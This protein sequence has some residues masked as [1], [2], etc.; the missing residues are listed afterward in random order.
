MGSIAA[1][2]E[3]DLV[4]IE[5]HTRGSAE[6]IARTWR[7]GHVSEAIRFFLLGVLTLISMSVGLQG[8]TVKQRPSLSAPNT[9]GIP[10]SAPVL[11]GVPADGVLTL[12]IPPGAAADQ[13]LGGR[14]YTM[15]DV[16]QLTAGD[17]IVLRNDDSVPHMILYAFLMPGQTHE[18]TLL[19]PGSEVYSSGCGVH[20]AS[21]LNF[22]TIFVSEPG[23]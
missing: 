17:T 19:T 23:R 5:R 8:A 2:S 11:P 10:T 16:I 15:P 6:G 22:T 13:R 18:R 20:G 21:F 9:L 4:A 3:W 12:V 7:R 14:G 1:Q